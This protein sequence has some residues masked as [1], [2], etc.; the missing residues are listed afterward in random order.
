MTSCREPALENGWIR[1]Q[2]RAATRARTCQLPLIAHCASPAP[3]AVTE[4]RA[5]V[6]RRPRPGA[7][8]F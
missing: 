1:I 6:V 5:Y 7:R 3:R 4:A 8:R 2:P